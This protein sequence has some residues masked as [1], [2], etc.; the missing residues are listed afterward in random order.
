MNL[1]TK[2]IAVALVLV[3]A[4]ILISADLG[5]KIF[6][7]RDDP[8]VWMDYFY[9]GD[10]FS[11]PAEKYGE[12]VYINYEALNDSVVRMKS[13]GDIEWT[14]TQRGR[15]FVYAIDDD[16]FLDEGIFSVQEIVRDNG[17]DGGCVGDDGQHAWLGNC[18]NL[19][20]AVDFV[21]YHWKIN[22]TKTSALDITIHGDGN[23]CYSDRENVFLGPLCK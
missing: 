23:Y 8:F 1:K 20:D 21:D 4:P 11:S 7:F 22:G 18:S 14:L 19:W 5:T 2:L 13:N 17:G 6:K 3:I 9:L 12:D 10:D 15:A 16:E